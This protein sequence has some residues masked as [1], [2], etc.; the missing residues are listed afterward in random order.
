[1]TLKE[2][3]ISRKIR[4]NKLASIAGV[5]PAMI[6]RCARYGMRTSPD[7][8]ARISQ[9]TGGLVS[10]E[11]LLYPQGLPEDARISHCGSKG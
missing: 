9:A 1:M 2:Y 11:E 8:A 6:T 10:I 4:G 5:S 7:S 3:L